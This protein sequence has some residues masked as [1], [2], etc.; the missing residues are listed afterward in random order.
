M[1]E[2][3]DVCWCSGSLVMTIFFNK[4][5]RAIRSGLRTVNVIK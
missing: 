4:D 5:V 1:Y 3:Y 2:V